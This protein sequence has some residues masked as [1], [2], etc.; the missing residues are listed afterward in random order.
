MLHIFL[1]H[2]DIFSSI[3][4]EAPE[5]E[6][7]M[8]AEERPHVAHAIELELQKGRSMLGKAAMMGQALPTCGEMLPRPVALGMHFF[9]CRNIVGEHVAQHFF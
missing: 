3:L 9:V 8:H 1:V 5:H 2:T 6:V 7:E 4:I